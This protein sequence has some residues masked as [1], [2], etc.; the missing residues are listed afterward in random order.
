MALGFGAALFLLTARLRLYAWVWIGLSVIMGLLNRY[1]A[2]R[3]YERKVVPWA[4]ERAALKL[5]IDRKRGR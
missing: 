4:A 2:R 3:W 1:L 5:E